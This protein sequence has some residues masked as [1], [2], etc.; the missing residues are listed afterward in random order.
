MCRGVLGVCSVLVRSVSPR[1]LVLEVRS[2]PSPP[3]AVLAF[4]PSSVSAFFFL[5]PFRVDPAPAGCVYVCNIWIDVKLLSF[6]FFFP[7]SFNNAGGRG[8][9]SGT[10]SNEATWLYGIQSL[11]GSAYLQ[12]EFSGIAR[13]QAQTPKHNGFISR[14]ITRRSTASLMV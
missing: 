3:C 13:G 1:R 10:T 7:L 2:F 9:Q 6:S 8:I 12:L 14:S 5:L 4:C 11:I